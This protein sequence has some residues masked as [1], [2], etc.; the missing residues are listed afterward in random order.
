MWRERGEVCEGREEVCGGRGGVWRERGG[1]WRERRCVEGEEVCEGREEV[2][3][4]ITT[5][6]MVLFL[7]GIG[8]NYEYHYQS[9]QYSLVLEMCVVCDSHQA[10]CC[11]AS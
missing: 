2:C 3:G 6:I 1:V 9:V 8:D 10:S 11:V 7:V 4:G 5:G